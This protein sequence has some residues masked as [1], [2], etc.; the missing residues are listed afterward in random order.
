MKLLI[1]TLLSIVSIVA[2][3][4]DAA[5]PPSGNTTLAKQYMDY[6]LYGQALEEYK[7]ALKKDPDDLKINQLIAECYLNTTEDRTKAIPHLEKVVKGGKYDAVV[8]F[9]LGRAY[10]INEELDKALEYFNRYKKEGKLKSTEEV[11]HEIECVQTA[12]ELIKIPVPVTFTNLGKDV[13]TEYFDGHPFVNENESVIYFTTKRKGTT[14]NTAG[15]EGFVSDVYQIDLKSNDK[16]SKGKS[17]GPSVNTFSME[18]ITSMSSN[19]SYLVFTMIDDIGM[20]RIKYCEKLGKAKAFGKSIDFGELINDGKS[21]QTAG[22]ISNDGQTCIFA[23]DRPGG[24]GGLDLYLSIKRPNGTWGEPMNLGSNINT[25]YDETYPNFGVDNNI[26]YFASTGHTNMGGFD[27]FKCI[28]SSETHSFTEPKNLGYPINTTDNNYSISFNK[29][30][31]NAYIGRSKSSGFGNVDI[32]QLT[33]KNTEPPYTLVALNL[34]AYK[35]Y[36]LQIHK[37]DS[38]ID[39]HNSF[40]KEPAT[41]KIPA[42]SSQKIITKMQT[43]KSSLDPVAGSFISVINTATGKTY[44]EYTPNLK[45]GRAVMILE[46]G[47]YE[48]TIT[49]ENYKVSKTKITVLDKGNFVAESKV[50][51]ILHKG[52]LDAASK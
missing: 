27:I 48:V 50:D 6:G 20:Q 22:C 39:L 10:F 17:V 32:Y 8:L 30:G 18:E 44:G 41:S 52:E 12:K 15:E 29:S 45:T 25:K 43:L 51:V 7:I 4:Q 46:P 24:F 42:D 11:D 49:N 31:R 3:A 33:F 40:L 21:T 5:V 19:G 9:D 47:V 28:F 35:T 26:L 14:G 36:Q 23:S 1:T 37:A 2:L 16:W 38:L 13:N 34:K